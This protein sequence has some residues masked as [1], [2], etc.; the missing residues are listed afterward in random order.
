MGYVQRKSIMCWIVLGYFSWPFIGRSSGILSFTKVE[1]GFQHPM[2]LASFPGVNPNY[3][4]NLP[5][6]E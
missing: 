3:D 6:Q 2:Y 5:F 4:D 1:V